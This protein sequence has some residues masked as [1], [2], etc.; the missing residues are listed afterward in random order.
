VSKRWYY[1]CF[2]RKHNHMREPRT[3][4]HHDSTPDITTDVVLYQPLIPLYG[5]PS[6]IVA[7]Q[8]TMGFAF[9]AH[10]DAAAKASPDQVTGPK[11]ACRTS[12]SNGW[13]RW[14][15]VDSF[16]GS[17]HYPMDLPDPVEAIQVPY[18]PEWVTVVPSRTLPIL[19]LC[20]PVS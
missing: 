15:Q 11:P 12:P 9:L 14:W 13:S 2:G 4:R 7:L 1:N 16:P 17:E 3:P 8:A 20:S 5:Y 10:M 19:C 18:G 6:Y